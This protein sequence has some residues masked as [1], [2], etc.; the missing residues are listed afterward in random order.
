MA[1]LA[2]GGNGPAGRGHAELQRPLAAEG[3]LPKL[4]VARGHGYIAAIE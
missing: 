2:A 1:I 3:D 4:V